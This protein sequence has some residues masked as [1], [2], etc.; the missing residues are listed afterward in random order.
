MESICS[1]GLILMI[2]DPES[3]RHPYSSSAFAGRVVVGSSTVY[4]AWLLDAG[5]HGIS[6][7]HRDPQLAHG[8]YC[9]AYSLLGLY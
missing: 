6:P 8:L 7:T 1:V 9:E 2:Y 4:L 5:R 3:I